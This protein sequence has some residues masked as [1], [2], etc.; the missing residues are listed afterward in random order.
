VHVPVLTL[1]SPP[2]PT[3]IVAASRF[4]AYQSAVVW[5]ARK[6]SEFLSVSHQ[7]LRRYLFP[8]RLPLQQ[9]VEDIAARKVSGISVCLAPIL[10]VRLL[11]HYHFN[12]CAESVCDFSSMLSMIS[13]VEHFRRRACLEN[14]GF[15][16]IE[17][18]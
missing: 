5:V 9:S 1:V 4:A 18:D 11:G 7:I 14:G 8:S 17:E 16:W 12:R 15:K 10:A 3:L 2:S 6:V 13:V